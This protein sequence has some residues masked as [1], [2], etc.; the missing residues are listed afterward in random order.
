MR[1]AYHR[2]SVHLIGVGPFWGGKVEDGLH[3][4]HFWTFKKS[5][6]WYVWFVALHM[7]YAFVHIVVKFCFAK[8]SLQS[9]VV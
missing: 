1:P 5:A 3:L 8:L 4:S 9:C 6:I 2:R 7:F